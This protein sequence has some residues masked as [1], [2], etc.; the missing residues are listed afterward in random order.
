[1]NAFLAILVVAFASASLVSIAQEGP[2][3][4]SAR[5]AASAPQAGGGDPAA[6]PQASGTA[7]PDASEVVPKAFENV[8]VVEKL[9]T[10]LNLN[11]TFVN[12]NG[13]SVK[14][15]D[16]VDGKKP[17]LFTLNY[18]SCEMLCNIQLN[19]LKEGLAG[20][21][22]KH[23]A[24]TKIVTVSFDPRDTP[25]LAR[26]KRDA[27]LGTFGEGPRPEWHFLTGTEENV[28]ALSD[29]FGF[30]YRWDEETRQFAHTAAIF[31]VS[32]RGMISRYLYGIEYSARD[33]RFAWIDASEGKFG[34]KVER[35]LLNCFHYDAQ[36]GKYTPFAMS[37]VRVGGLVT[38][39]FLGLFL[40]VMWRRER[41]K[42][43]GGWN[44]V[45]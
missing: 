39:S 2:A 43:A 7:R 8:T 33:I 3:D 45:V 11:R 17:V 4:V 27:L 30:K 37:M 18:Y 14:L 16:F 22:P 1:M 6:L 35:L 41:R 44:S 36:S 15:I 29:A 13:A 31:F 40:G 28:Q 20:L 38:V 19:A 26:K 10:E 25:E 23:L 34:S 42:G 5:V 21:D 24:E 32:P 9:G 12:E